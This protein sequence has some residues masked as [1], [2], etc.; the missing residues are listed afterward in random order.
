MSGKSAYIV[1]GPNGSGKTTFATRF[2][3]EDV[4]CIHFVNA[5]LIAQ[6]LSP[7]SPRIA[8]M[9]AGRL[10]LE[11]IAGYAKQGA[12]FAFE[13][14]LAGKSYVRVF[15]TL[16]G[17]G[18]QLHL[19]FLW[20][21]TPELASARIRDRVKDGGHDVP[22]AD[23]RRR[24]R[25]GIKNLFGLYRSLVDS[26]TLFGNAGRDPLWIAK[27]KNRQLSIADEESYQTILRSAA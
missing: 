5:D 14:T 24:F 9:R 12:D 13:T 25:R 6:G 11:Q 10:V 16:R 7:F 17:A 21:P 15:K 22:P 26:W 20:I 18:Y 8:A 3:P 4:R 2:L 27:E 23:V 1:A 19:F